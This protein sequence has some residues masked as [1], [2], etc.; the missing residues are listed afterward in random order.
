MSL[1]EIINAVV[2]DPKIFFWIAASVADAV[3]VNSNGIK[4]RLANGVRSFSLKIN[5][6]L[7]MVEKNWEILL[8][9]Y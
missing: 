8:L 9:D 3:A 4:K 2:H 1:F 7:L 6:L 5:Q